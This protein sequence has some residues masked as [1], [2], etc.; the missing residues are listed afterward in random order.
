MG[1]WNNINRKISACEYDEAG[2]I[3]SQTILFGGILIVRKLRIIV[4]IILILVLIVMLLIK[5]LASGW[6]VKS[7]EKAIN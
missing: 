6:S 3:A 4:I 5:I 7:K 1:K 2:R